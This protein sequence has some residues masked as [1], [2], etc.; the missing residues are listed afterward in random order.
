MVVGFTKGSD[1]E[2]LATQLE[3]RQLAGRAL[4]IF[5]VFKMA[6]TLVNVNPIM[7]AITGLPASPQGHSPFAWPVNDVKG[8]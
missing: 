1:R 6:M 8:S 4:N 5:Y 2:R 7:I 3:S